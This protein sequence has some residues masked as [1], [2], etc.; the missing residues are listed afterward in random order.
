MALLLKNLALE[1]SSPYLQSVYREVVFFEY[2][3]WCWCRIIRAASLEPGEGIWRCNP[4]NS[5]MKLGA[6]CFIRY[7]QDGVTG[8]S[9]RRSSFTYYFV[10]WSG[11][12][13]GLW[14]RSMFCTFLGIS[15]PLQ[16][17]CFTM[18]FFSDH[19][20]SE[21]FW[22]PDFPRLMTA[23]LASK[24]FALF[25]RAF[26]SL[27]SFQLWCLAMWTTVVSHRE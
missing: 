19:T 21:C 10:E 27:F 15:I 26:F 11:K 8:T 18:S 17:S 16:L 1:L 14:T 20:S 2:S 3:A 24:H 4:C 6:I 13:G 9:I 25:S 22:C 23:W 5:E 7:L 12:I